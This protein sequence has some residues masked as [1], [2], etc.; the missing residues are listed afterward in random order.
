[1]RAGCQPHLS[2]LPSAQAGQISA[3]SIAAGSRAKRLGRLPILDILL[4][5]SLL[6][7][8]GWLWGEEKEVTATLNVLYE[9]KGWKGA[10]LPQYPVI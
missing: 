4:P 9:G 6:M 8:P 2:A 1:M 5:R 10:C 7:F 3:A